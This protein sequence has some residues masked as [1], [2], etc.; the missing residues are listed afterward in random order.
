MASITPASFSLRAESIDVHFL[1]LTPEEV[2]LTLP[3][4]REDF[5]GNLLPKMKVTIWSDTSPEHFASKTLDIEA[6]SSPSCALCA[7]HS[8]P[9]CS[10]ESPSSSSSS[11]ASYFSSSSSVFL[12]I[13][14][15]TLLQL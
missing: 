12:S 5:V 2:C 15:L 4:T 6:L 3:L 14:V 8:C 10:S 11:S 1:Y 9:K 13:L 7:S